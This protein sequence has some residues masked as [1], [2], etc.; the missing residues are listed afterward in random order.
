MPHPSLL[1]QDFEQDKSRGGMMQADMSGLCDTRLSTAGLV[2]SDRERDLKTRLGALA[3][4]R[5]SAA[6][7]APVDDDDDGRGS[8]GA[9]VDE[10]TEREAWLLQ[11]D[12]H[13]LQASA[14]PSGCL[15]GAGACLM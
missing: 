1:V 13:A 4:Q 14:H 2:W 3:R 5:L 7:D 15:R 11:L 10:D 8:A 9:P 6:C 12:L